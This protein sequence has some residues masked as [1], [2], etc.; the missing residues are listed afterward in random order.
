LDEE[1]GRLSLCNLEP[2]PWFKL[3][4]EKK[5]GRA[6]FLGEK[7]NGTSLFLKSLATFQ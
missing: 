2:L 4:K 5:K 6:N 7:R 1:E 3:L